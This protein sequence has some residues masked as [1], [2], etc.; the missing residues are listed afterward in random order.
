MKN[1]NNKL[2]AL[3]KIGK[4]EHRDFNELDIA[5]E[6]SIKIEDVKKTIEEFKDF[7]KI[8]QKSKIQCFCGADIKISKEVNFA[9]CAKCGEK[10]DI[11]KLSCLNIGIDYQKMYEYFKKEILESLQSLDWIIEEEKDNMFT[12][13]KNNYRICFSFNI[14]TANLND[15]FIQRGWLNSQDINAYVLIRPIFDADLVAYSQKDLKCVCIGI[16][17]VLDKKIYNEFEKGLFSRISLFEDN[18]N[19]E[20]QIGLTSQSFG[21]LK[22]IK[23]HLDEITSGI[24]KFAYQKGDISHSAQGKKYQKYIVGL[25]NLSLFKTKLLGEGN[26]PDAMVYFFPNN[27]KVWCPVEIKSSQKEIFKLKDESLQLRK[28]CEALSTTYVKNNVDVKYFLLIA[29][30]FEENDSYSTNIINQL[31]SDFNIKFIIFPLKSVLKMANIFIKKTPIYIPPE[32]VMNF[33]QS[34][35][36]IKSEDIEKLHNDLIQLE[37]VDEGILKYIKGRVS[38]YGN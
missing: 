26:E 31:E 9:I 28:Y 22:E 33:L 30:D 35:R 13:S 17:E 37:Q 3:L 4:F 1:R 23:E 38:K 19:V 21:D 8:T 16:P 29:N 12:M 20:K 14:Y 10:V 7:L 2:Y 32:D 6:I 24:S 34:K 18:Q 11:T 27:K 25:F 36:Y 5:R 15:Y